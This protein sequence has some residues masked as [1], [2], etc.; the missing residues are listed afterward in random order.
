MARRETAEL[1]VPA[2]DSDV[3]RFGMTVE[4]ENLDDGST[5]RWTIVGED[6]TDPSRGKISHVAPVSILLFGKPVGDVV[7][8]NGTEWEIVSL[9]VN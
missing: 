4:L 5:R 6:E 9:K 8:I 1:S 7:K 3:V 2:P